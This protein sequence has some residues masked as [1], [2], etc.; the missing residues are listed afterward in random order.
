MVSYVV[1]LDTKGTEILTLL[2]SDGEFYFPSPFETIDVFKTEVDACRLVN[3]GAHA[4]TMP[5]ES[6]N[7]SMEEA[8]F[9]TMWIERHMSPSQN[10][11]S[12]CF[13]GSINSSTKFLHSRPCA[14]P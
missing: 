2:N 5:I 6:V 14:L 1:R 7:V 11:V 13:F 10:F 9:S 12:M 3:G 4:L 8:N